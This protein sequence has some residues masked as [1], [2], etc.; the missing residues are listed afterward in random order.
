[1]S[2][3]TNPGAIALT[4]IPRPPSASASV[5]VRPIRPAFALA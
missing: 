3:T 4:V 1:M 5:R 2:L